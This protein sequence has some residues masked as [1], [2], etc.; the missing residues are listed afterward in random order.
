MNYKEFVGQVQH[1]LEYAEFGRA[2]RATRAVLTTLGE[3]LHEGEATDLASPLPMEI[4]R[5]L[6]EAD[7]GQRFDYREF[8]DRV[9]DREGVDRADA[10]YHAQ[11]VLAVVAEDVPAGNVEKVRNQ[12]PEEFDRLF[13]PIETVEE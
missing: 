2:V 5:Y 10:N 12:L 1:R 4:D 13:E 8:L 9:A 6:I 11:Q 3:R 7:H